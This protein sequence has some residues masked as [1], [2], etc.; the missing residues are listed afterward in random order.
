MNFFK[1]DLDT[2]MDTIRLLSKRGNKPLTEHESEMIAKSNEI[3]NKAM[4]RHK[5]SIDY[6]ARYKR[7]KYAE[8]KAKRIAEAKAPQ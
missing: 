5:K 8:E 1:A 3:Y 7:E 6:R 4:E 2:L